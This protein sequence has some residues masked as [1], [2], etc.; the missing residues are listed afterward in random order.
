MLEVVKV[1]NV[2]IYPLAMEFI[3][4]QMQAKHGQPCPPDDPLAGLKDAQQ[5]GGLD[6]DP[7]NE[8]RVFVAAL[9]HPYG[10]K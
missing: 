8:N 5:I 1:C 4:Q 7:K 10:P 3:N 9:G 2:P 6:V